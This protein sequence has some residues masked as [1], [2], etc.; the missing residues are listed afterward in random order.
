MSLAKEVCMNI[1]NMP[2][3]SAVRRSLRNI[4]CIGGNAGIVLLTVK[5]SAVIMHTTTYMAS[6]YINKRGNFVWEGSYRD[7]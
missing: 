5:G 3:R 7:K 1:R 6:G 4:V 2:L